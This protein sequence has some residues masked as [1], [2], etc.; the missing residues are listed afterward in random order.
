MDPSLL[1]C[2]DVPDRGTVYSPPH[3]RRQ[4]IERSGSFPAWIYLLVI[5]SDSNVVIRIINYFLLFCNGAK[6]KYH[7]EQNTAVAAARGVD[8][9]DN[10]CYLMGMVLATDK[11][12]QRSFLQ[13]SFL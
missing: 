2:R 13:R 8:F 1:F 7:I 6:M 10:T 5:R 4:K 3:C 12:P 9:G 11:L